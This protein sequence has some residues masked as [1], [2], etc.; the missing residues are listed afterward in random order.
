MACAFHLAF[1]M[2]SKQARKSAVLKLM[3]MRRWMAQAPLGMQYNEGTS[4]THTSTTS[5]SAPDGLP[6]IRGIQLQDCILVL[7]PKQCVRQAEDAG[8]LACSWGALHDIAL[9]DGHAVR[10]DW[11]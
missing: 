3:L 9:K 1:C 2:A 6:L 11:P 10:K 7:G 5:V 4:Q 8:C